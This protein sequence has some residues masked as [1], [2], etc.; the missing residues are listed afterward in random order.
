[1]IRLFHSRFQAGLSRRFPR[2]LLFFGWRDN[3]FWPRAETSIYETHQAA[4]LSM[5][6]VDD[7]YRHRISKIKEYQVP[8]L[9]TQE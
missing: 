2:P 9:P 6:A 7:P 3:G 1:M 8:H 4:L 5:L